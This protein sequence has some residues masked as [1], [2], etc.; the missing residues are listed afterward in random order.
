MFKEVLGAGP[1]NSHLSKIAGSVLGGGDSGSFENKRVLGSW[2]EGY[3]SEPR[4]C[5]G[6]GG[7]WGPS[8]V[9][10]GYII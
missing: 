10:I 6:S 9:H 1:R 3:E 4:V 2:P 5:M 7:I 8:K